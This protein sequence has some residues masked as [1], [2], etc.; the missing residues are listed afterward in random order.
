MTNPQQQLQDAL[1][2]LDVAFAPLSGLP[3]SVGG[4]THCYTEADLEVL[5]GAV[6]RVPDQLLFSVA[7]KTPDHWDNFPGLYRRLMPRIVHL[8]IADQLDHGLVASRLLAAGWRNWS[9]PEHI[10]LDEVWHAWWR[11]VLHSHPITGHI[12]DILEALAVTTGTLAPW[13]ALWAE[14]RTEAA[15]LHLSDALDYWLIEDELAD[16]HLGFYDELHATPQL[17]P[18]L[19][20]LEDGRI[21]ATQLLEVQRISSS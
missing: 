8:L 11:S 6:H 1:E 15:D 12:T 17:L 21:N 3:F 5:G 16:L 9:A 4:C 14:T 13:L 20:S 2:A 19:L 10:A 7:L 18:W